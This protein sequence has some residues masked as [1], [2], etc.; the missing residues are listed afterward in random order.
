MHVKKCLL[1]VFTKNETM[2]SHYNHLSVTIIKWK[3]T[4]KKKKKKNC[5]SHAALITLA[6]NK[7]NLFS[8]T[9]STTLSPVHTSGDDR[10]ALPAV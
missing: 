6:W 3:T 8:Q 5:Y 1:P 10:R 2:Q 4:K 9:P 7:T